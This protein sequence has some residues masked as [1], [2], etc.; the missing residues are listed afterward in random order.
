MSIR[1]IRGPLRVE[2]HRG[3]LPTPPK[4]QPELQ[5]ILRCRRARRRLHGEAVGHNEPLCW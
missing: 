3:K 4:I 5:E 2:M 1:D